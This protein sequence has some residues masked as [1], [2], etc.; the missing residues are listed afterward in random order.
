MKHYL[1]FKARPYQGMDG[2]WRIAMKKR[3][4]KSD[5]RGPGNS[6]SNSDLFPALLS[7]SLHDAGISDSIALDSLPDRVTVDESKFLNVVTV[8]LDG[9]NHFR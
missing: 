7:R 5:Y 3:F 6:L 9:L 2:K 1:Q 4:T 8:S